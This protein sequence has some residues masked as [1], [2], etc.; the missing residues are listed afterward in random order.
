MRGWLSQ[1][2]TGQF[3]PGQESVGKIANFNPNWSECQQVITTI[4]KVE[5]E[6]MFSPCSRQGF[7]IKELH[8]E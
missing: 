4:V 5:H 2:I 8:S 7:P 6:P 1:F 3:T